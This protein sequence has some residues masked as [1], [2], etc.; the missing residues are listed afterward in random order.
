MGDGLTAE[1]YCLTVPNCNT[2][3]CY[4]Y[5]YSY[6]T[7]TGEGCNPSMFESFVTDESLRQ[8]C[9]VVR[10]PAKPSRAH[11]GRP[12]DSSRAAAFPTQRR[13]AR[14]LFVSDDDREERIAPALAA[15]EGA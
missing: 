6:H 4:E 12:R 8:N 2:F 9:F 3:G 10:L 15:V 11:V 1:K 7:C 5:K 13:R 14:W